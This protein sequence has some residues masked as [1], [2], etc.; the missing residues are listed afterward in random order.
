MEQGQVF[1][2]FA[3]ALGL[4]LLVGLQRERVAS[5]LAGFRTF[6]LVT[7]LGVLCALLAGEFGGWLITGGFLALAALMF[8]SSQVRLRAG[9]TDPGMTTEIA[10][11]LMFGVGAY[12]IVGYRAVAVVL[13][14][15]VAVLLY[16]KPQLHAFAQRIG[17][18]D[19]KS[20]MQFVVISLVILP[21]LPDLAY[22][23]SPA[24][25]VL[26]PYRI[27]WLVVLIVG[28]S[29][30]GYLVYKLFGDKV[31]AVVGGIVGGLISSTATTV[32]YARR[33]REVPGSA[34]LSALVIMLASTVLYARVMA[35]TAVVSPASFAR[36]A[37]P[38]AAMLVATTLI[39]AMAWRSARQETVAMLE[40]SNPSE[41]K[42]AIL[43]AVL[44][45][46]ILL[47]I[48]AAKEYFGERGLYTVA[49]L[50]G[51]IDMDAITLSSSQMVNHGQIETNTAWRLILV[52]SLANLIFK[53]ATVA[54]LGERQLFRRIALLFGLTFVAGVVI[55]VVW[56]A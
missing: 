14:G 13:G 43:F 10:L 41:L 30:G 37:A 6:P 46:V 12:L 48:T 56:P 39:S 31:G 44:F 53:G 33:S 34:G 7:M 26:N 5:A 25:K 16:L 35:I 24:L 18:E 29:L 11:L 36:V 49:T 28:L 55:L 4:G 19:F 27:W 8:A 2:D 17:D 38:L 21:V 42:S 50:S 3:I 51:L 15:A 47:A 32:S 45:A 40:H 1:Q 20:I 52:A 54:L 9:D 22:G 23:P